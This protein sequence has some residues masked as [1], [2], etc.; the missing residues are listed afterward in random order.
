M[1]RAAFRIGLAL[2]CN[3]TLAAP[4]VTFESPCECRDNHGERGDVD[5]LGERD[6]ITARDWRTFRRV[7]LCSGIPAIS[8][9][10]IRAHCAA[11]IQ[12]HHGNVKCLDLTPFFFPMR[13][14]V[15]YLPDG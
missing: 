1:M 6:Q 10:A 2:L 8:P 3:A 12:S 15:G 14:K 4:L 13:F 9:N 11:E 7:G 5:D